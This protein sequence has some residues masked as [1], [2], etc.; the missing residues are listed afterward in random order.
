M[1]VYR[2]PSSSNSVVFSSITFAFALAA[3]SL[4][5]NTFVKVTDVTFVMP[6]MNNQRRSDPLWPA[7][8]MQKYG[9]TSGWAGW[10]PKD[11]M[12]GNC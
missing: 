10:T 8:E 5:L 2:E 6:N 4:A 7:M 12:E 3:G 1:T 11:D 9:G